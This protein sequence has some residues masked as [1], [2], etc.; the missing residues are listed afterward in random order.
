MATDWA[1]ERLEIYNTFKE[2]GFAASVRVP[3]SAGVW[4]DTTMAYVGATANTDYT[5]YAI[6]SNFK[7]GQI[8]GSIVQQRD[9]L[10]LFSA[11]GLDADGDLGELPDL[12]TT[13][14]QLVIGGVEQNVISIKA[15]APGNVVLM[16]KAQLR[17]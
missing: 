1:A 7:A 4:N 13:S 11:Y 8:D 14:V 10:L 17:L 16:Y 9:V 12:V 2:E 3:G 6:K 5:V 15:V